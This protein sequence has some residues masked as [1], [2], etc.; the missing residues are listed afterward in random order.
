VFTAVVFT[1]KLDMFLHHFFF[2]GLF[3]LSRTWHC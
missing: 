1:F 2:L 3:A